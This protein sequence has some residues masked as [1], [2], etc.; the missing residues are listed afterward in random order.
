MLL[1]RDRPA[2]IRIR[3]RNVCLFYM[4]DMCKFPDSECNYAHDM[5]YLPKGPWDEPGWGDV[6][7]LNLERCGGD[8]SAQVLEAMAHYLKPPIRAELWLPRNMEMEEIKATL[9]YQAGVSNTLYGHYRGSTGAGP[10]SKK[11]KKKAKRGS[12]KRAGKGKRKAQQDSSMDTDEAM[13][14]R[15]ANLGF[16]NDEVFELACQGVKPWDDDAWVR[17]KCVVAYCTM[18]NWPFPGCSPRTVGFLGVYDLM[19]V[20]EYVVAAIL[21]CESSAQCFA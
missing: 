13:E 19:V 14:E 4:L 16:T 3:G 8:R 15:M 10:S 1:R 21:L 18:L 12:G 9:S 17:C 7:Q 20:F 2:H 5:S 11:G 6:S